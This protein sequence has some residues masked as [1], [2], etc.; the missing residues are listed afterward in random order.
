[1]KK[2][3]KIRENSFI[4]LLL[5]DNHSQDASFSLSVH[6]FCRLILNTCDY[7]VCTVLHIQFLTIQHKNFPILLKPLYKYHLYWLQNLNILFKGQWFHLRFYH[8]LKWL[9]KTTPGTYWTSTSLYW[10]D[11][12]TSKTVFAFSMSLRANEGNEACTQ[13]PCSPTVSL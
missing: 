12:R 4:F 1:M 9:I 6:S 5:E 10:E 3:E 13:W 2:K 8:I 7:Y 11:L